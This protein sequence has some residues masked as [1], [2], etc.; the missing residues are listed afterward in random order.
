MGWRD[1]D[2]YREHKEEEIKRLF[3]QQQR[4]KLKIRD[5]H[6]KIMKKCKRFDEN[7]IAPK[8]IITQISYKKYQEEK[9]IAERMEGVI[10]CD[11]Y[12]K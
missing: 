6:I 1:C 11:E 9:E 10:Y 4:L 2:R 12:Y 7:K 8:E 3:R 5:I